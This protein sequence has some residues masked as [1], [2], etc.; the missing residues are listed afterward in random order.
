MLAVILSKPLPGCMTCRDSWAK[1]TNVIAPTDQASSLGNNCRCVETTARTL[2]RSPHQISLGLQ[3]YYPCGSMLWP[4]PNS[5]WPHHWTFLETIARILE[6]KEEWNNGRAQRWHGS[7]ACCRAM[8][9]VWGKEWGNAR[10]ECYKIK[11]SNKQKSWCTYLFCSA[12]HTLP[13]DHFVK[14]SP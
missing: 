8:V 2:H 6:A 10:W 7:W 4:I 14:H 5:M 11:T 13:R 9:L 1:P 3:R 12:L